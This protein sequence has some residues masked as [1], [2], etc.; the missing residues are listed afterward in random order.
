MD[1]KEILNHRTACV[2]CQGPM[3]FFCTEYP[4]MG[5]EATDSYFKLFSPFKNTGTVATFHF[6]GK[7]E[8]AKRYYKLYKSPI[9]IIRVCKAC[10]NKSEDAT[11]TNLYKDT[12]GQLMQ[13][14]ARTWSHL[15]LDQAMNSIKRMECSYKF[16]IMGDSQGNY[17][18][19]LVFES[20]KYFDKDA[21]W[22]IDTDFTRGTSVLNHSTWESTLDR[23]L[24]FKIPET[25]N[26]TNIKTLEQF[27][28]KFKMIMLMS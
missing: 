28:S 19:N 22:H 15:T 17:D 1:L 7:F 23:I 18:T 9:E 20:I 24:N 3:D 10:L 27:M 25:I 8:K 5:Y 11:D 2:F 16:R 14:K 13:L 12:K 6:D 4:N 21:F 26:L